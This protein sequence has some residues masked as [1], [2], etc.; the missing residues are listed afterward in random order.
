MLLK[1]VEGCRMELRGVSPFHFLSL[2]PHPAP[3]FQEKERV[4]LGKAAVAV[5]RAGAVDADSLLWEGDVT[6]FFC[7]QKSV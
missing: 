4:G 7:F 5:H 1:R 2:P 6:S 3:S